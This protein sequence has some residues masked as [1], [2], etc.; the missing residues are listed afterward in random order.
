MPSDVKWRK[1]EKRNDIE[2]HENAGLFHATE[3]SNDFC[4]V[5]FLWKRLVKWNCQSQVKLSKAAVPRSQIIFKI[6]VLKNC[7]MFA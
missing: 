7:L 3:F 1:R 6:D 5:L 4:F 2:Y